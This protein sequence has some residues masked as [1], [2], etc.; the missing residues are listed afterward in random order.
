MATVC[1]FFHAADQP[2]RMTWSIADSM[3]NHYRKKINEIRT[4]KSTKTS[5]VYHLLSRYKDA[6][7]NGLLLGSANE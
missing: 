5:S 4:K 1:N 6:L 7:E 3:R 2:K